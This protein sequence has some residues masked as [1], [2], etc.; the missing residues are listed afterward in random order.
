MIKDFWMRLV[1]CLFSP[2]KEVN[3]TQTLIF[4]VNTPRHVYT[5]STAS[6]GSDTSDSVD[7][8]EICGFLTSLSVLDDVK[9]FP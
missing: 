1:S 6:D 8:H 5:V 7:L 2:A 3:A 4:I 9:I